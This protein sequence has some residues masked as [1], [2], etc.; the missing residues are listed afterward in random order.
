MQ[1]EREG[2]R[3]SDYDEGFHEMLLFVYAL[4]HASP[5]RPPR[6]IAAE[7]WTRK[8]KCRCQPKSPNHLC[9]PCRIAARWF[10][11]KT[12]SRLM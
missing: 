12:S 6:N 10:H 1:G 11:Y 8:R 5:R 2:K 7:I 9:L 3:V 4:Y